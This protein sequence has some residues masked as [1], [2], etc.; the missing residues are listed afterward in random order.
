MVKGNAVAVL[1]VT[2]Q[3]IPVIRDPK[4]PAPVFWKL[5]GGRSNEGVPETAEGCAVRELEEEIG[6]SLRES[7]L[8]VVHSLDKGNH[9]LT[10]FRADLTALPQMKS[11]GNEGEEIRVFAPGE[12]LAEQGFFPNHRK[13]VGG[14]LAALP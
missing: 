9:I 11:Q 3:G 7:D 8:T 14:I 12:L 10:I 5:P 2:P 13:V 1:L 6:V 4:K